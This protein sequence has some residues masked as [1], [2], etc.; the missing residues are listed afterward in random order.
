MIV[1]ELD[2]KRLIENKITMQRLAILLACSKPV[3][4]CDLIENLNVSRRMIQVW[5]NENDGLIKVVI[6]KTKGQHKRH[7]TQALKRTKKAEKLIANF[8][9]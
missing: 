7:F 1:T 2:V 8:I 4:I 3:L 9:Q 5:V 6:V